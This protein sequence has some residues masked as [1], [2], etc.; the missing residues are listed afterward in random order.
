MRSSR[1]HPRAHAQPHRQ[2][3]RR[4]IKCL[5]GLSTLFLL[6]SFSVGPSIP[7][8][9]VTHLKGVRHLHPPWT[10]GAPAMCFPSCISTT[11][12][13][14]FLKCQIDCPFHASAD[15]LFSAIIRKNEDD[16]LLTRF[17]M[18][19]PVDC[20][21]PSKMNKCVNPIRQFQS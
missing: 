17:A 1:I 18:Q 19:I 8:R 15:L 16:G 7:C 21:L 20:L 12:D 14:K 4:H 10:S 9:C 6:P 13:Q 5:A 2:T 3:E 11:Q